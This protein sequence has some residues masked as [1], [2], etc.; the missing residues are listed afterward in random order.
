MEKAGHITFY[1]VNPENSKRIEIRN[2]D[3]LT[4]LQEKMM[5]TQPD[6]ILQYAHFLKVEY[7][8]KGIASPIVKADSYVSLNGSGSRRYIDQDTDLA[9]LT[10]GFAHKSW[11]LPFEPLRLQARK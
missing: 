9:Q 4:P 3:Y 6:M 2:S 8:Q 7:Q 5:A 10:E 11:L 1:V